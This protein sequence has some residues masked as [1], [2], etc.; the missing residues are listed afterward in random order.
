[1]SDEIHDE[2]YWAKKIATEMAHGKGWPEVEACETVEQCPEY[3][4][5]NEFVF[6][7]FDDER[8]HFRVVVEPCS[9]DDFTTASDKRRPYIVR[10]PWGEDPEYP[11]ADWGREASENNTRLGYWDWV[12]SQREMDENDPPDDPGDPVAVQPKGTH[13]PDESCPGVIED[14]EGT[15]SHCGDD[16]LHK[17]HERA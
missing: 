7:T 3:I 12:A 17:E 9:P 6:H 10:D 11:Q 16:Y 14:D 5:P 1:M 15:C 8:T 13:C 2:V 4:A